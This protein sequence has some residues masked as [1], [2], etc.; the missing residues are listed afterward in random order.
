M[1][2]AQ[3]RGGVRMDFF[4]CGQIEKTGTKPGM[5]ANAKNFQGN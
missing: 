2:G 1:A 4:S 3:L 5:G